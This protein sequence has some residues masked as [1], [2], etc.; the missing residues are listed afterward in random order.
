MAEVFDS[1]SENVLMHLRNIFAS[2]ESEADA[3]TKKFL[4]VRTE[5][6][7]RVGSRR[8]TGVDYGASGWRINASIRSAIFCAGSRSCAMVQSAA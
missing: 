8:D 6:R 1:T 2:G 3:T 4:A 5:G 7:R